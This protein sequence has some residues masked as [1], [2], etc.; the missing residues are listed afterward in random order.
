MSTKNF[1]E[2]IDKLEQ[3][4]EDLEQ[5]INKLDE[6]VDLIQDPEQ[7][8]HAEFV[9]DEFPEPINLNTDPWPFPRGENP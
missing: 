2:A 7:L 8:A 1:L 3:L 5:L 4:R 6:I 9:E